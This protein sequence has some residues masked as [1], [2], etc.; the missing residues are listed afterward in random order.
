[1]TT[2][3]TRTGLLKLLLRI[4]GTITVTAFFSILLP[5][6][7]MAATHRWLGLGELPRGPVVEYLARSASALYGFHGVLLL[8]VSGDPVKYRAIVSF[9]AWIK[10]KFGNLIKAVVGHAGMP[11]YWTLGEGPPII[12]FGGVVA[13][14][15]KQAFVPRPVTE[16]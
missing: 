15:N 14:L 10:L 6:E 7:W 16:K 13:A 4:A 2:R 12:A 9:I 5:V 11:L 8:V 3:D 1:M